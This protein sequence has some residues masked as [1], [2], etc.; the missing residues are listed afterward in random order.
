MNTSPGTVGCIPAVDALRT[1][2]NYANPCEA[3]YKGLRRWNAPHEAHEGQ[4]ER[5]H[6]STR[7]YAGYFTDCYPAAH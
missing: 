2:T 7:Y 5:H 4:R 3:R 1:R 6:E